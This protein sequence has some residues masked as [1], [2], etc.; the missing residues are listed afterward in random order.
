MVEPPLPRG[1]RVPAVRRGGW[2]NHGCGWWLMVLKRKMVLIWCLIW[3]SHGDF[4]WFSGYFDWHPRSFLNHQIAEWLRRCAAEEKRVDGVGRCSIRFPDV[5]WQAQNPAMNWAFLTSKSFNS[6]LWFG[7]I[8]TM[9]VQTVSKP[10]DNSF[11]KSIPVKF[12]VVPFAFSVFLFGTH[13]QWPPFTK[14]PWARRTNSRQ[15]RIS[16]IS[17]PSSGSR[18]CEMGPEIF[19]QPWNTVVNLWYV[20]LHVKARLSHVVSAAISAIRALEL[21]RYRH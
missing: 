6:R 14:W 17:R 5:V 3:R 2:E 9:P 12:R 8:W 21:H 13:A 1:V 4:I 19:Q 15:M 10:G 16:G 7:M 20:I 18:R 11:Y